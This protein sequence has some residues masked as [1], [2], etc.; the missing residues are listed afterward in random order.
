MNERFTCRVRPW[1][2]AAGTL[3]T[4][5][6]ALAFDGVW[7]AHIDGWNGGLITADSANGDVVTPWDDACGIR[8]EG[9]SAYGWGTGYT[10]GGSYVGEGG[11]QSSIM[12]RMPFAGC[13]QQPAQ[14][15]FNGS[16][17]PTTPPAGANAIYVEFADGYWV[18]Q[19]GNEIERG[20]GGGCG[21]CTI[22]EDFA[23]YEPRPEWLPATKLAVEI[24]QQVSEA[25]IAG[26]IDKATSRQI[27]TLFAD[28]K[29][30][31]ESMQRKQAQRSNEQGWRDFGKAASRLEELWQLTAERLADAEAALLDCQG[32]LGRWRTRANAHHYCVEAERLLQSLGSPLAEITDIL[33]IAYGI[34]DPEVFCGVHFSSGEHPRSVRCPINFDCATGPGA[35]LSVSINIRRLTSGS[36]APQG[37]HSCGLNLDLPDSGSPLPAAQ[38]ADAIAAAI[39]S[40][41]SQLIAVAADPPVGARVDIHFNPSSKDFLNIPGPDSNATIA[42]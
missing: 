7:Y 6:S 21:D 41:C 2:F 42:Y 15:F 26:K 25:T 40:Q 30:R 3:L 9:V 31:L 1:L 11:Y 14:V 10:G 16:H 27:D 12:V 22:A 35:D 37:W 29:L 17:Q 8:F 5:T 32:A 23:I 38:C 28:L 39:E 36:V 13:P 24:G 20:G 4:T 18:D 19:Y 34:G 33:D